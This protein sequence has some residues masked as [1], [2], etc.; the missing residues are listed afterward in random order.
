MADG[1]IEAL[2]YRALA[3]RAFE[4][5]TVD[6]ARRIEGYPEVFLYGTNGQN[7]GGIDVVATGH[8]RR[9]PVVYQCKQVERFTA[10]DLQ[11][12]VDQ[13]EKGGRPTGVDHLVVVVSPKAHARDLVDDQLATIN[14][15]EDRRVELWDAEKLD[16]I[17]RDASSTVELFFGS[18]VAQRFCLDSSSAPGTV[19]D[20]LAAARA[21]R[22]AV[23]DASRL[24]DLVA[25][26]GATVS[27]P[28]RE[29]AALARDLMGR[30]WAVPYLSPRGR[31]DVLARVRFARVTS[32]VL[33]SFLP[34]LLHRTYT[35]GD[36]Y[37]SAA[38]FA[39]SSRA[40]AGVV[41]DSGG[42]DLFVEE[43]LDAVVL[44]AHDRVLAAL[45]L[46]KLLDPRRV[47]GLF[48]SDGAVRDSLLFAMAS[49][50]AAESRPGVPERTFELFRTGGRVV[51]SFRA[52]VPDTTI[53]LLDYIPESARSG[54]FTPPGR[55]DVELV[56]SA[57]WWLCLVPC[58]FFYASN[59]APSAPEALPGYVADVLADLTEVAEFSVG[60]P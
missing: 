5:L 6:I 17:L 22:P 39:G 51:S 18:N 57:A 34:D 4:K 53:G 38:A 19:V 21:R 32:D 45:L 27:D 24:A 36:G 28:G 30:P 52:H 54:A 40:L 55:L 33:R 26:V 12:V 8:L 15:V 50:W 31:E 42:H 11:E 41:V 43:V 47:D 48:G 14:R 16:A 35:A 2:P 20:E 23:H 56:D 3:P 29:P 9:R 10:A 49:R 60:I 1:L 7:Q 25:D 13:W 46:P 37:T 59:H 44:A 58:A